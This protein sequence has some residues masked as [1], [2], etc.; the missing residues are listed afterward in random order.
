VHSYIISCMPL[1]RFM[2]AFVDWT[3]WRNGCLFEGRDP[4][5]FA[6]KIVSHDYTTEF[7]FPSIYIKC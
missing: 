2:Q 5:Q 3:C 4:P 1:C 6:T 7:C